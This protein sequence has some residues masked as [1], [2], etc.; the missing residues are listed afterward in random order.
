M[1][2]ARGTLDSFNATTYKAVVRLDGSAAMTL[3]DVRT[4]RAIP[5]AEMSVGRP[6]LVDLG[7]HGDPS[8]ALVVAVWT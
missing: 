4:S 2:T 8:D 6:V 3:S 7:D 1:A 5:S